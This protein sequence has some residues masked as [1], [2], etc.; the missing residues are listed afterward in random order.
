MDKFAKNVLKNK[1]IDKN[2][3]LNYGF[4][5]IENTFEFKKLIIDEQFLLTIKIK[6]NDIS[7]EILELSTNEPYTLY[8][9]EGAVG[10][11][12]GR[13]REE[14]VGT[15][16]DIAKSCFYRDIFKEEN[17]KKIIEYIKEKYDGDLE[18]LW[19]KSPENAIWRRKDN[20]KWYGALLTVNSEKLGLKYNKK[21]EVLDIRCKEENIEK[22][23]D[24]IIFFKGYHMNKKSWI[25]VNLN[26]KLNLEEIYRMIDESY[27]LALK[28]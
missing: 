16:N 21:L 9:V 19:E 27:N 1:S 12:V 22:L 17:S 15:L 20:K 3:L 25:T 24:N 11:F 23:V 13:V 28:K 2:K 8:L 18:Y 14:Y 26:E 4:K 6:E 7:S 10:S 5:K